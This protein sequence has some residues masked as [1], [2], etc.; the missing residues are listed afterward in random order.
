MKK[1]SKEDKRSSPFLPF[2][3]LLVHLHVSLIRPVESP[4]LPWHREL[5]VS[6]L[7]MDGADQ[8]QRFLSVCGLAQTPVTMV[9]K[10]EDPAQD[11][12]AQEGAL[13]FLLLAPFPS[14]VQH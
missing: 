2:G 4:S 6:P 5:S 3:A 9:W 10:G 7:S 12:T 8:V 11:L 13:L 14:K 1:G